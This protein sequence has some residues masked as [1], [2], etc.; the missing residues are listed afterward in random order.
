MRDAW[1][2]WWCSTSY[3]DGLSARAEDELQA[4]LDRLEAHARP[5]EEDDFPEI[6]T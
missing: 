3:A 6:G 1:D 2:P 5:P 4:E